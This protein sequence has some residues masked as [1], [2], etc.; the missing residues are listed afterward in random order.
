MTGGNY[1]EGMTVNERLY[2]A[3]RLPEFDVATTAGDR[4]TMVNILNEVGVGNAAWS[5]DTI[6]EDPSRFGY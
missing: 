6:L 4:V 2:A 1:N 5:A 3:G